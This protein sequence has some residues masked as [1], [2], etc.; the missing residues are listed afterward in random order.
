MHNRSFWGPFVVLL[1]V[2]AAAAAVGVGAYNAGVSH[3]VAEASRTVAVPVE[4]AARVYVWPGPWGGQGYGYVPFFP[5]VA[6]VFVLLLF[7]GLLMRGAWHGRGRCGYGHDGVPPAFEE[8]HRRAHER[9]AP[10]PAPDRTA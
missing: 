9:Q 10:P 3:G 7:R 6:F 5:I 1:L 8:W 2:L 4:G